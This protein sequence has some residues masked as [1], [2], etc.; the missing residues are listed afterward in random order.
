M[1]STLDLSS[2]VGVEMN[3]EVK[4]EFYGC[5]HH[6]CNEKH[7]KV[8]FFLGKEV[9]CALCSIVRRMHAV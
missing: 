2:G 4:K 7:P 9:K 8:S 3:L 5:I 1:K 6:Y